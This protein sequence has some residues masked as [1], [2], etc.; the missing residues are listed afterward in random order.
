MEDNIIISNINDFLF[1]PR[2]IYF[3]NLYGGYD[4]HM[5]HSSSQIQGKI[6]HKNIDEK[7]YTTRKSILQGMEIYSE[8][9][10]VV[11]K[12]DLFDQ[13]QG[14]LTERKNK[15]A[16]VYE[17][18]L[19]QI[20]AQYFCLTEMGYAVKTIR[21]YSIS[22]NKIHSVEIPSLKQKERLLDVLSKMR[23]FQLNADFTQNK[24]KC[25]KCIY[26]HLCDYYADDEQ[27]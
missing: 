7:K 4:E 9:L 20:Y 2:S 18:Y 8:E 17:G 10:G 1:C 15:I 22:D 3:H 24:N 6:S 11:G 19:L 5:Y 26:R 13:E 23:E 16:F 27:T 21:L 25:I 12:I 14:I